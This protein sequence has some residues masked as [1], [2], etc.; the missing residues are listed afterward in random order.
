[1]LLKSVLLMLVFAICIL[2]IVQGCKRERIER[3]IVQKHEMMYFK[4]QNGLCYA[5]MSGAHGFT[6]VPCD[7]VGLGF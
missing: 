6:L 7:K 5:Y 1:M 2:A 4:D 3:G